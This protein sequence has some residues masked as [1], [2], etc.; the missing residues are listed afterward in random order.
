[1]FCCV[2]FFSSLFP[3]FLLTFWNFFL[4][5]IAFYA[6]KYKLKLCALKEFTIHIDWVSLLCLCALLLWML[7]TVKLLCRMKHKNIPI[8]QYRESGFEFSLFIPSIWL[9][10]KQFSGQ[11]QVLRSGYSYIRKQKEKS[12]LESGFVEKS[13]R[14]MISLKISSKS[15]RISD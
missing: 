12:K 13:R 9:N 2:F 11:F 10:I 3:Y 14:N 7:V 4:P 15:I 8:N 6:T 1:M 5:H